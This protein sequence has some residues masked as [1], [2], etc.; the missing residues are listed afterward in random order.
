MIEAI[1]V[2][3]TVMASEALSELVLTRW[4]NRDGTS[5]VWPFYRTNP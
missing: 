3:I 2:T 1:D 4:G 5:T